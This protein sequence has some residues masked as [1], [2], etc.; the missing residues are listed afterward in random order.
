MENHALKTAIEKQETRTINWTSQYVSP[1]NFDQNSQ[2]FDNCS[3]LLNA[4]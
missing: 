3:L 2:M 4:A 1:A